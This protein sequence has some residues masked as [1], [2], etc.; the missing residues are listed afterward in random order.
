M[1]SILNKTPLRDEGVL[2]FGSTD[3]Y[4]LVVVAF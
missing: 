3:D 4:C 2:K 1:S